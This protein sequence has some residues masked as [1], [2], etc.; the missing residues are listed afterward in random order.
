MGSKDV[1]FLLP[2]SM[3]GKSEVCIVLIFQNAP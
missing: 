1:Q 2:D 3:E